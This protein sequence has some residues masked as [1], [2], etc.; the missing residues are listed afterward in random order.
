MSP[1]NMTVPLRAN[2]S[3][4]FPPVFLGEGAV[5]TRL[6]PAVVIPGNRYQPSSKRGLRSGGWLPVMKRSGHFIR[7]PVPAF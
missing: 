5:G 6:V 1:A 3:T 2:V 4:E 7:N